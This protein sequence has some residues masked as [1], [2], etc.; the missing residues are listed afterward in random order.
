[1]ILSG[2]HV[3]ISGKIHRI[4]IA[5]AI[6]IMKGIEPFRISDKLTSGVMPFII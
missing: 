2:N 1:M 6:I 5:N 4:K 3:T